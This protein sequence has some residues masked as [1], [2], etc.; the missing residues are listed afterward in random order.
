MTPEKWVAGQIKAKGL[1]QRYIAEKAK[2]DGF[3]AQKLSAAINGRRHLTVEEFIAVC[4]VISI[5]PFDYLLQ[6]KGVSESA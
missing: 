3:T 6:E 2:V 5:N 1:K 4:D